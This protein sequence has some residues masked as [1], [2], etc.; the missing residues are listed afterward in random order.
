MEMACWILQQLLLNFLL[1]LLLP[2]LL[3]PL[4]LQQEWLQM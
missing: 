2:P 3:R 4:L 1:W